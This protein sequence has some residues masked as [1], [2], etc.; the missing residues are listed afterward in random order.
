MFVETMMIMMSVFGLLN[1]TSGDR[2]D[3]WIY[4]PSCILTQCEHPD[5]AH[6]SHYGRVY[7]YWHDCGGDCQ[8]LDPSIHAIPE[9]VPKLDDEL[10]ESIRNAHRNFTSYCTKEDCNCRHEGP[11]ALYKMD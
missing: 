2:L 10:K 9:I 5:A 6:F 8:L 11:D 4:G 7:T 3:R 1:W